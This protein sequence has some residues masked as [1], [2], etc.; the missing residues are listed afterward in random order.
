MGNV[1]L[2]F[3]PSLS[4]YEQVEQQLKQEK[5][6]VQLQSSSITIPDIFCKSILQK[7]LSMHF[8]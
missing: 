7:Y 3:N 8:S 1:H 5:G 6:L 2:A 4:L